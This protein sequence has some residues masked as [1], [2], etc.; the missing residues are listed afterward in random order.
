MEIADGYSAMAAFAYLT[1][2]RYKKKKEVIAMKKTLLEYCRLDTLAMV[3]MHEYLAN[4]ND[5]KL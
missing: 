3:K 2:G 4:M 5:K 1:R